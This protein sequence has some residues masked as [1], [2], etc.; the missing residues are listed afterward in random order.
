[1]RSSTHVKPFT[2]AIN[3][4]LFA[5]RND[6]LDDFYFVAFTNITKRLFCSI[7][8]P[9]F[10][11]DRQIAVNNLRHAILDLRKIVRRKRRLARKIVIEPVFDCGTNRHLRSRKQLLH[12]LRH[13]VRRIVSNKLKGFFAL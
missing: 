1:M 6:V 11:R 4:D 8:V 13:H 7:T 3:R 9:N 5:F 10:P 2:L 12:G